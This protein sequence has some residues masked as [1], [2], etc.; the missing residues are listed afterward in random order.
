M[1]FY[2]LFVILNVFLDTRYRKLYKLSLKI[3]EEEITVFNISQII[4][5]LT[6][7]HQS[8]FYVRRN[9]AVYMAVIT[10]HWGN[11]FLYTK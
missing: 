5:I 10:Q 3:D 11:T 7:L 9:Q 4:A 2:F 1:S 8:N 6:G